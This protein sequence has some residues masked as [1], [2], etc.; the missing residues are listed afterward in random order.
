MIARTQ[1]AEE[2]KTCQSHRAVTVF[3][4]I[5]MGWYPYPAPLLRRITVSDTIY[6]QIYSSIPVYL[7]YCSGNTHVPCILVLALINQ[8]DYR[9]L[10]EDFL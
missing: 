4:M 7:D 1:P 6:M 3:S 8:D 2:G 9:I 10:F 5:M